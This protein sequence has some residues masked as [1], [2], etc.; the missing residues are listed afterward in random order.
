MS[1]VA[2]SLTKSAAAGQ[3]FTNFRKAFTGDETFEFTPERLESCMLIITNTQ[4]AQRTF[5]VKKGNGSAS[6]IGDKTIVCAAG[7]G[8]AQIGVLSGLDSARFVN[9]SGK[10]E[11][12]IPATTTGFIQVCQL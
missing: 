3:A 11:V 7:D 4:A 10:V 6:G 12:S 8:T 2:L 5:T 1:N 9:A